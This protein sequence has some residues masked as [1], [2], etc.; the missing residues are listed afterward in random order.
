MMEN[1]ARIAVVAAFCFTAA[2]AM[3]EPGKNMGTKD[4]QSACKPDVYR[5]CSE[6]IP[7]ADRIVACLKQNKSKLRPACRKV[8]AD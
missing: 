1:A 5:L 2:S 8:F 4:E 6:F 3:A 7:V